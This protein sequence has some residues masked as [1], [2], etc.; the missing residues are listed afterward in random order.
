MSITNGLDLR[1]GMEKF[2]LDLPVVR[3]R[4]IHRLLLRSGLEREGKRGILN[5]RMI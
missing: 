2:L 1:I 5:E 4:R 3:K